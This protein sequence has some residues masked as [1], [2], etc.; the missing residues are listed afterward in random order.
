MYTYYYVCLSFSLSSF[1]SV[2]CV[3]FLR[4]AGLSIIILSSFILS[5]YEFIFA[6]CFALLWYVYVCLR[7]CFHG[8]SISFCCTYPSF[9][10]ANQVSCEFSYGRCYI[11]VCSSSSSSSRAEAGATAAMAMATSA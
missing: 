10:R 3:C 2:V 8:I 11:P 9:V 1:H 4:C 5:R 7:L 6:F